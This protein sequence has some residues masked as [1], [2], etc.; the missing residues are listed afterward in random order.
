MECKCIFVLYK[1]ARTNELIDT[2]WNVN[3][4]ELGT[5]TT[6]EKE[7]IDTLWNVNFLFSKRVIAG[8]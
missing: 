5:G 1:R 6:R 2:L 3:K 7:L 4:E 8:T